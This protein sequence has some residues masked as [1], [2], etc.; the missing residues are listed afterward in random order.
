MSHHAGAGPVA[1]RR[2]NGKQQACEPC[3]KAKIACDHTLPSCDRCKRRRISDKCIYID[4]PM[5]KN[6]DIRRESTSLSHHHLPSPDTGSTSPTTAA[7]TISSPGFSKPA[8]ESGPFIKSGGFFGPTNFSAVFLENKESLGN[9]DI[10]ISNDDPFGNAHESVQSQQAFLMLAGT[11]YRGSPRVALGVKVLRS[12]PDKATCNFLLEWYFEKC[13]ECAFHQPTVLKTGSSLWTTFG[14]QLKEPRRQDDLEGLSAILCKNNETALPDYEDYQPWLESFTGMNLRW[15]TLGSVFAALTTATLSL[16]ERDAF[17]CT[18][19][20]PRSNRNEFAV[21]M[22]DCVQA[23]IT[24]SNYQDLINIQMVSLLVKNLILQTVISGDTSL[25]VWRQLGDLVSASTALGLHREVENGPITFGSEMKRRIFTVVFNIDKGSSLLTG[26]PPALSYRYTRFKFPMDLNEEVIMKGGEELQNAI[27]RLDADGW[28]TEGGIY[29]STLSRAHGMVA[30]VLN[31]ILECS[32]GDPAECTNTRINFLLWG[33]NDTTSK[34]TSE[35]VSWERLLLRLIRLEHQ[36]LLERLAYKQGLYDG[37]SM[38]DCAREM[39][40]LTV[41][42]WV[43]RDRFSEHHCDYDWMLMCWGVP[44]SGVLCVEL[45]KQMKQP[46]GTP[47]FPVLPRSEIVQNL[48]LLIG[49]LDWIR[50]AAGNYQLCG[51]MRQIIKR[52]LDQILNPSP[53]VPQETLPETPQEHFDTEG[54]THVV[55]AFDASVFEPGHYDEGLANLDWLN[56]V[57]WSRGPWIDLGGQ[58]YSAARWG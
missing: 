17:F 27:A 7:P 55:E 22:K 18:Q 24:L 32:L 14:K 16:P 28:N 46:A 29:P 33:V 47:Y 15:E 20:G 30:I 9:E 36:L 10:Q 52:I 8:P 3:R 12:L 49:F 5:T 26:R 23:C 35:F 11:D 37:Q 1:K 50:P 39:L 44:S 2:R 42:I 38:V 45:L 21:E 19:K 31:E 51:R 4:A 40:E 48:S 13:H 58:D 25:L 41:L 57:D 53:P 6:P 56:S 34:T 43:Q 54:T